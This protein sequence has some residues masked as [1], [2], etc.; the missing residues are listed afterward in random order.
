MEERGG[1]RA[2]GTHSIAPCS[3]ATIH[4]VY[5]TPAPLFSQL[6]D[7][8]QT[9]INMIWTERIDNELLH[10]ITSRYMANCE[11]G[12]YRYLGIQMS[13]KSPQIGESRCALTVYTWIFYV[14]VFVI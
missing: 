12:Q 2:T 11:V 7:V 8:G 4:L 1:T 6:R 5:P 9:G 13:R 10:T 14:E 3:D